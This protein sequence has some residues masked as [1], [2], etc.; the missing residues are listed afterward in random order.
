MSFTQPSLLGTVFFRT[1]LPCSGSY[2][3]E[4]GGMPLHDEVGITVFVLKILQ[5]CSPVWRL[6]AEC[7]LQL[8]EHQALP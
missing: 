4:R 6:A 5:Y 7:Q 1:P 8:I 3:M 2:H